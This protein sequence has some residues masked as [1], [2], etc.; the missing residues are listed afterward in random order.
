MYLQK[1]LDEL[2]KIKPNVCLVSNLCRIMANLSQYVRSEL[3]RDWNFGRQIKYLFVFRV[4]GYKLITGM[5]TIHRCKMKA[6]FVSA[7]GSV[8]TT[9]I[10]SFVTP[11]ERHFSPGNSKHVRGHH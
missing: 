7:Q 9:G 2:K 11:S 4:I 3:F 10:N 5:N 8:R 6:Q 1:C